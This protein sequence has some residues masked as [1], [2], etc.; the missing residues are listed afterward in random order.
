MEISE[1]Q[2]KL[3]VDRKDDCEVLELNIALADSGKNNEN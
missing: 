3:T 1:E 2:I